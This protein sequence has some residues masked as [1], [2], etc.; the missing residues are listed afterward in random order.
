MRAP[1]GIHSSSARCGPSAIDYLIHFLGGIQIQFYSLDEQFVQ[2][3][4]NMLPLLL[5]QLRKLTD[6]FQQI[7]I[8]IF[9][10]IIFHSLLLNV[11]GFQS[12]TKC[13]QK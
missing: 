2:T 10:L 1:M 8:D 6:N 9:I 13:I 3:N 4:A 11:D 7:I 5:L 12:T